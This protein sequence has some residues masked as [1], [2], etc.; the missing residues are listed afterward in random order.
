[1]A[2]HIT[3]VK[4]ILTAPEGI[5]LESILRHQTLVLTVAAAKTLEGALS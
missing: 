5:N 2:T 1:M 4:V 3:D